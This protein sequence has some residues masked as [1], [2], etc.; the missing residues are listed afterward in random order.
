MPTEARETNERGQGRGVLFVM[1]APSAGESGPVAVWI[2][3]ANWARA[4]RKVWGDAW[5]MTPEGT[6]GPENALSRA[7]GPALAPRQRGRW[8]RHVP[9][10][11]VTAVKDVR[12]LRRA[13][14]FRRS[15]LDRVAEVGD[16]VFVWQ[17]HEIFHDAGLEIARALRRPLVQFVDAPQTWEDRKWGVR[18][19]GWGRLVERRGERPQLMAA[20]VVACVSDEVAVM[21]RA[22]GVPRDRIVVTPTGVDLERFGPH[23]SGDAV[24]QRHGLHGKFVVGWAGSFRPFH[25][26][27]TGLEAIRHLQDSIP[28]LALLLVGDGQERPRIVEL[29]R[30][31]GLRG[32]VFTGTVPH[33]RMG[34]YLSAMDVALLL[35]QGTEGYHYSPLKLHEYM[36]AG[37][38]V[39]APRVGEVARSV[40]H[41]TEA[42]L[43]E[44]GDTGGFTS[45]IEQ[46]YHDESLRRRLGVMAREKAEL[47]WSWDE[48]LRRVQAALDRVALSTS[49]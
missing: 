19:P 9:E 11:L 48:Q 22:M 12:E 4:A 14:A 18:R 44:P 10:A 20:D 49:R 40:V 33:E 42:L 17:H 32:V 15:A 23:I 3:A 16:P 2:T 45:A 6:F 43:V 36:A 21:I 26:L 27:P 30:S 46:L 31:M 47:E 39:V 1:P 37:K 8:R 35:D 25:A 29:A 38:P 5:I 28:D 24:R 13:R 7:S 34:E 41:G